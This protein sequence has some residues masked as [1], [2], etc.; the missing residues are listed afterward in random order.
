VIERTLAWLRRH[1]EP[2]D[3]ALVAVLIVTPF[4]GGGGDLGARLLFGSS[5]PVLGLI[6]LVSC[7]GALSAIATR[8]PG[9]SVLD[10]DHRWGVLGPFLGAVSLLGASSLGLLGVPNDGLLIGPAFVITAGAV[11]LGN[12]LPVVSRQTRRILVA[13]FVLLSGAIL[14]S[15]VVTIGGAVAG[16]VDVNAILGQP[17]GPVLLFDIVVISL[18]VSWIFYAM[19]VYAPR[20][21]ASPGASARSWAVRFGVF[22]L[23]LMAGI[24]IGDLRAVTVV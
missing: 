18:F 14:Q 5:D 20:E 19:L 7:V 1:I 24:A 17:K 12:R 13:P 15:L 11:L 4:L 21:L 22:F 10:Q 16:Q 23:T 3:I 9:E 2:E 6:A 8:V